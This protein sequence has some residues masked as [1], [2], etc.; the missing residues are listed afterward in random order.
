MLWE[1]QPCYGTQK[2]VV[3]PASN[4]EQTIFFSRGMKMSEGGKLYDLTRELSSNLWGC[5]H[6]VDTFLTINY[7]SVMDEIHVNYQG[8]ALVSCPINP[9]ASPHI[10]KVTTY[11]SG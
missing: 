8:S 3:Q 6:V 2:S 9:P 11:V 5:C 4:Q 1:C 7:D 10:T